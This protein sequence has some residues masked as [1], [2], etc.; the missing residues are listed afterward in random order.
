MSWFGNEMLPA[1]E[2]VYLA[3]GKEAFNNP[4]LVLIELKARDYED[5]ITYVTGKG[6]GSFQSGWSKK[7]V[8]SVTDWFN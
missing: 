7:F 4:I 8:A 5:I 3:L 2:D 6:Q 1:L